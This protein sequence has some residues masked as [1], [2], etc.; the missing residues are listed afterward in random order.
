MFLMSI[1]TKDTLATFGAVA[2][3]PEA[4]LKR[5]LFLI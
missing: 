5:T 4:E 3:A 1:S 2:K